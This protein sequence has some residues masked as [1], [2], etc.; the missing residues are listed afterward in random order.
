M[1]ALKRLKTGLFENK[2]SPVFRHLITVFT[3]S[4]FNYSANLLRG[5]DLWT[6]W[7]LSLKI[8]LD[9]RYSFP[10]TIL[11]RFNKHWYQL[12]ELE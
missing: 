3:I 12:A 2:T 8:R 1:L 7:D 4:D 10:K 9:C 5:C 6:N 11:I